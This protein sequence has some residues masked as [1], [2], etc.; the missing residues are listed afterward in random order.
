MFQEN[1][2][3]AILITDGTYSYTIFTYKCGLMGWD[4]GATIGF[5]GSGDFFVNNDPSTSA[6]ACLNDPK[7]HYSNII[8]LLSNT[9]SE[10]P[11]PGIVLKHSCEY[12]YN[13]PS[14]KQM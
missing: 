13:D 6:V 5:K 2:F 7:S 8:Y 10:I 9:S 11:L 12:M 14:H 4:N 3:E 1:T